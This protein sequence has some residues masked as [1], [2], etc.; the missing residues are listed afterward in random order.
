[1]A[2]VLLYYTLVLI[3]SESVNTVSCAPMD[4]VLNA[5]LS[6]QQSVCTYPNGT[7]PCKLW[8]YTRLDCSGRGLTCIPSLRSAASL[9]S[10]DLTHNSISYI[11]DDAFGELRKLQSLDLTDNRLS[12]YNIKGVFRKLHELRNLSLPS[13]FIPHLYSYSFTGLHK[14]Q[15]LKLDTI[16]LTLADNAFSGLQSLQ[17][18]MLADN[19][20]SVIHSNSLTGLSNLVYLDLSFNKLLILGGSPFSNL[21]S[22]QKL[23]VENDLDHSTGL[24]NT[25]LRGLRN[26]QQLLLKGF[27]LKNV[28]SPFLEL[29]S[30][31]H[32]E[33]DLIT[34]DVSS[35]GDTE[36]LFNGLT[37][38]QYLYLSESGSVGCNYNVCPL[39]SLNS[40]ILFGC[41]IKNNNCLTEIPLKMLEHFPANEKPTYLPYEM[42]PYLTNLS[43]VI[44]NDIPG[45]IKALQTSES[46]LQKLSIE[47][48]TDFILNEATLKL[49]AKWNHSLQVLELRLGSYTSEVLIKNS[50]F[51]WF[52]NLHSLTIEGSDFTSFD[53]ESFHGLEKLQDL[54]LRYV[55]NVFASGALQTFNR[56]NTLK[57]LDFRFGGMTGGITIDQFCAI[58][59]SLQTI[60]LMYNRFSSSVGFPLHLP[61]VLQN[62]KVL[63][64]EI[65]ID[66]YPNWY[67]NVFCRL[68]PNLQRFETS[69]AGVMVTQSCTSDICKWENLELLDL[70][71]NY[72]L[73][74]HKDK[75]Y[76][77]RLEKLLLSA[78]LPM[79]NIDELKI[80]NIFQSYQ[81]KYLDLS[82]NKIEFIEEQDAVLLRNLTFLS[83]FQNRLTSISSLQYLEN[84]QILY[85]HENQI[86]IVPQSF[87]SKLKHLQRL[88]FGR[89]LLS[90]DCSVK[91][92]AKWLLTD[93]V[94]YLA[95]Y[96]RE[97][98]DF[99]C[100]TPESRKGLSITEID[101][102]C[103]TPIWLYV[104]T[105]TICFIIV[106]IT[107]TLVVW[108]RWHIQYR[109][110]LLFNRRRIHQ[111]ILLMKMMIMKMVVQDLMPL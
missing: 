25:V 83:L 96:I 42:L 87:L 44:E 92:L 58:S 52:P 99:C 28:T 65:Q 51:K 98:L 19:K 94:V 105:S 16:W 72:I 10:L 38:L 40:I 48:Y 6:T 70:S 14:L 81:L 56:Y 59:S 76:V 24:T 36:R 93:K 39:I 111:T 74:N 95:D 55:S 9:Y 67:F 4:Q 37:K 13:N 104:S 47:F 7:I 82:Q 77:P 60:D 101:L 66:Y 54:H 1:M 86:N 107:V 69:E 8:N 20:L 43:I 110:F 63:I 49:C 62:L 73:F 3:A 12:Y 88:S 35:C 89:N 78:L 84:I 109:L 29:T 64:T 23:F 85:I 32:L 41:N 30:L 106:I 17:H 90:C 80:V 75:I 27:Y 2:T 103:E 50:P 61:C 102:D 53:K 5:K 79:P 31:T 11:S 57:F 15:R 71:R 21:I 33:L 97:Y 68:A 100:E 22:L 46:Q 18:L 108:Y 91:A 45:Q 26:L 34:D